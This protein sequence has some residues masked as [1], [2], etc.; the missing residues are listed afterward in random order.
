[1]SRWQNHL[2]THPIGPLIG[3][4][5]QLLVK[6]EVRAGVDSF[7]ATELAR[8][9]KI[10]DRVTRGVD[11]AEPALIDPQLLTDL[12]S[13][14]ETVHAVLGRY[15]VSGRAGDLE[16]ANEFATR[17]LARLPYI[18][19][20]PSLRELDDVRITV[21]EVQSL[22]TSYIATLDDD[23]KE[24]LRRLDFLQGEAQAA[25][26]AV[27]SERKRLENSFSSMSHQFLEQEGARSSKFEDAQATRRELYEELKT[28]ITEQASGLIAY[29]RQQSDT[30][31]V[32]LTELRTRAE[33]VV[34]A[35]AINGMAGGYKTIADREMRA[36]RVWQLFTVA[37]MLG[38]VWI[39]YGTAHGVQQQEEFH[40][41]PFAVRVFIALAVGVL[42]AFTAKQASEHLAA[43]RSNRKMQLE[44]TALVPYLESLP[45]NDQHRVKSELVARLFA[46][47]LPALS[48]GVSVKTDG[49]AA[50]LIK[51][52]LE[53]L[54]KKE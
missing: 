50:D 51:L 47:P 28:S 39:A 53:A 4:F 11:T 8:L 35:I 52:L 12:F 16:T 48:G 10:I 42:S 18:P 15:V 38:L 46:Q 32:R 14:L 5:P 34:G 13:E 20:P 25:V 9:R 40:W 27:E 41:G 6:A 29:F 31:S 44:L 49:N 21:E 3:E 26:R 2:A 43:E 33:E 37:S 36:A 30:E 54:A 23:R 17:L 22:A 7:A 19:A 24:L 45:E 1:M